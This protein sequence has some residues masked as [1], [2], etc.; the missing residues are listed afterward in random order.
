MKEP[1]I[2]L[3]PPNT[4]KSKVLEVNGKILDNICI[5]AK[6]DESIIDGNYSFDGTFLID[7][8]GLWKNIEEECILKVKMDYDYEVFRIVKPRKN[9][10]DVQVFARQITLEDTMRIHLA[11][12]RPT[13]LNG[14][15]YMDW[16]LR[17]SNEYKE[18]KQYAKDLVLSSDNPNSKT[19]YYVEKSLYE[20]L[21][22]VDNSFMTLWGGEVQRRGYALK[23]NQKIG[24][25]R[26]VEI[27]SGKNL[28]GFEESINID[29][30]ITRIK[31]KGYNGITINGY[32]SSGLIDN[33]SRVFTKEIKYEDVK[34]KDEN[35]NEGYNTLT[36]AQAELIRRANLEF[37]QNKVDQLK[38]EYTINFVDLSKVEEYKEYAILERVYLGDTI[39]VFVEKLGVNI[40][41]RALTRKYDVLRQMPLEITLSNEDLSKLQ[42]PPT[43]GQIMGEI[44]KTN[45]TAKNYLQEAKDHASSLIN[46]GLKNSYVVV[47]PN[48]IL[49]MDSKDIN[50]ATKVWRWNNGGLGFSSTGYNGEYGTAITQDGSIVADFITVGQ[51]TANLIRA[52]VIKGKNDNVVINLDT[53]EVKFKKGL[54]QGDSMDLDLDTGSFKS[55]YFNPVTGW[56][57]LEIKNGKITSTFDIDL[58]AEGMNF[59]V[60]ENE[61]VYDSI[62]LYKSMLLNSPNEVHL[63]APTVTLGKFDGSSDVKVKGQL[64]VNGSPI[65]SRIA[66]LENLKLQEEGLI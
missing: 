36:E 23:I 63:S 28:T 54:I 22:T 7:D 14:M 32:I 58:K 48:E 15:A 18:N 12:V 40:D 2:M 25:D 35:N 13:S 51:L 55:K 5:Q 1:K 61:Q 49:I 60:V 45:E 33:Y 17:N 47:R 34:V 4:P 42:N 10:R 62:Y 37:T 46:N 39:S 38:A 65:N 8:E 9:L 59:T 53:G 56:Q 19:A 44:D 64:T 52:G 29:N 27:K 16:G 43:L 21:H 20:A 31:P 11:D 24:V 66:N 50:T 3:Y 30:L 6:T 41:V 57:V 26:G